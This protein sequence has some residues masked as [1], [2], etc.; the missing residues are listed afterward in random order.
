MLKVGIT[1]GIGSGKSTVCALF[2]LL[3]IPVFYADEAARALMDTDVELKA[4]ISALFGEGIYVSGRL[5]RNALSRLV[6][7]D[8]AK[9]AA[10]NAVVHPASVAAGARWYNA[11]TA[12][13]AIKEAA[14]FFESGTHTGMDTMIG[15][16]APQELRIKRAME[17]SALSRKDVLA[18][19]VRQ[20]DESEKMA[21][22]DYV[23]IN[24]DATA[25][26]PQVLA[27]D[28]QLRQQSTLK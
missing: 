15:V 1:G 26:L 14:I 18:R 28:A 2:E 9:L 27:L 13:Y 4:V 23:I 16:S 22:C 24:D 20:M 19:M 10:L 11:Q 3:R 17:R 21:R 12:P 5:D 6:F 7:N 25:I 8:P